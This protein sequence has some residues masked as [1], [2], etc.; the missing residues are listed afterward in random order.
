[1]KV[2]YIL[3]A[4]FKSGGVRIIFEYANLLTDLGYDVCI[5]YPIIP[6]DSYKNTL[7]LKRFRNYF[8]FCRMNLVNIL[9]KN[10]YNYKFQIKIVPFISNF[11]IRSADFTFATT[12]HTAFA[13]KK[14]KSDKGRKV[15]FVQ[16]YEDWSANIQLVDESYTL[17]L[18]LLTISEYL[19]NFLL[20]KFNQ[21]SFVIYN[22]ID[23]EKFYFENFNK[24]FNLRKILFIDQGLENKNVK[25]L[26]PII[27]KLKVKYPFLEFV[28]FGIVNA[29]E[30]PSFVTFYE[31]PDDTLIRKLYNEA[32]LFLF[33]STFEGFG[34]PPAEAMLCKCAAVSTPVGAI[35]EY[36]DDGKT[37]FIIRKTD[38]SDIIEIVDQLVEKKHD[39]QNISENGYK[40]IQNFFDWEVSI[41]KFEN[42]LKILKN[43]KSSDVM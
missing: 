4:V 6:F 23:N 36:I 25:N 14:F 37:G 10:Y 28:S 33:P 18:H 1:M 27:K 40:S 20:K 5:Y 35:P 43:P 13:V 11:F 12:W 2:N 39:L 26:I 41:E 30:K 21:D 15:Y 19:K 9:T 32:D 22:G 7:S 24:D 42:Y 29:T 3:P 8:R 38:L 16:A 34:L 31:N 17:G